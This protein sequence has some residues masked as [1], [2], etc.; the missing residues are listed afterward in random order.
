MTGLVTLAGVLA[1]VSGLF[2][3]FGRGRAGGGIALLGLLEIVVGISA[4]FYVLFEKPPPELVSRVLFL[5]L[6]LLLV[7]SAIQALVARSERHKRLESEGSRLV[8]YVKYL[9]GKDEEGPG[10]PLS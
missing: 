7:S 6:G 3:L 9:S 4:P 8:T 2:K 10:P 5:T 1:I